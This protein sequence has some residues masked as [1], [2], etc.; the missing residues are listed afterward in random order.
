MQLNHLSGVLV[1]KV[2]FYTALMWALRITGMSLRSTIVVVTLGLGA[3]EAVQVY[4]PGRTPE[5]TD[6]LLPVVIGYIVRTAKRDLVLP[7]T[8]GRLK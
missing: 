6:I 5:T 1:E 8:S 4:L 7:G 3:I 2:F